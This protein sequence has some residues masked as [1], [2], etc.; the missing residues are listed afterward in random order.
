MAAIL[1]HHW[2]HAGEPL[3]AIEHLLVAAERA[4]DGWAQKEAIALYG[5]AL[6][7][8]GEEDSASRTRIRL[9]RG[10]SLVRLTDF[11]AG[12]AELDEILP[13]LTGREE[14]EAVLARARMAYWME[15]TEQAYSFADRSRDLA[16]RLGDRELLGPA[17]VYQATAR[18]L[19]GELDEALALGDQAHDLWVPGT[20]PGDLAALNECL[21][22]PA[23]WIGDYQA[24][25]HFARS[26]YELGGKS[27]SIEPLLRSGGWRGLALA[28]QGRTEEAIEWLDSIFERAQDLDPRW[29]ASALN[30]SSLAFR[31]M[32]MLKEARRRNENAL[33]IVRARGAWGMPEMQA[34]ID[35]M[36]TDLAVGDVGRVQGSFPKVWDAAI[37]GKAWRPWLGAG[38]LALVRAEMAR[39]A[40]GAEATIAY[41]QD[42][43]DRARRVR[44]RKYE[45]AARAVLGSALVKLG[46]AEQGIAELRAAV[47][48]SDGLGTPTA[49]WQFRAALA[50]ALYLTGDDDGTIIAYREAADVIRAYA[51]GLSSEHA[52]SFLAAEPVREV[53]K[54]AGQE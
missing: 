16:E 24:A 41:A 49:R 34:E 42:A 17:M 9:L 4:S 32:C 43:I 31:D 39:Q 19:R 29:G 26:A 22:Q 13:D 52:A 8:V 14:F 27:H 48:E 50:K 54:A 20:R 51:A 3:R 23:Y 35:L 2:R 46:R 33:E 15:E 11:E 45:A 44:R 5:A 40:E 7:L 28:A 37:N 18:Y 21:A 10:L 25:E 38:R 30:Y 36:F 53:L 1:A 47:L 12:A 6:E